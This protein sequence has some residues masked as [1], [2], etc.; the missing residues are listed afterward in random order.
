MRKIFYIFFLLFFTSCND[1]YELSK[2]DFPNILLIIAD[3]LGNDALS[4]FNNNNSNPY[5]PTLEEFYYLGNNIKESNYLLESP[6]N[7]NQMNNLEELRE[8]YNFLK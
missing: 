2:I 3:D 7:S 8:Y 1:E 6:L 5:T 4:G